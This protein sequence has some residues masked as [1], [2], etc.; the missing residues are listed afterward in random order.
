[1]GFDLYFCH[2]RDASINR[3]WLLSHL[4]ALEFATEELAEDQSVLQF[5]YEHPETGVYCLFDL[6]PE[7]AIA[8]DDLQL[9]DGYV[10]T[11]L[12]V[13]LNF[14]R[15]S[16]FALEVM[17]L[18]SRLS[19]EMSLWLYDPQ[20]DCLHHPGAPPEVLAEEWMAHNA[21]ATR[22][23]AL[24]AN[25]IRKPYLP[26]ASSIAWWRYAHAKKG[27]QEQL[28]DSVFV[29]AILLTQDSQLRVRQVVI[30]S[31]EVLGSLPFLKRVLPLPQV[32]PPCDYYM[33]SSGKPSAKKFST[34]FVSY[35]DVISGLGSLL[36]PLPGA[37]A[38]LRILRP[39][40]QQ[41]AAAVFATLPA[42]DPSPLERIPPEALSDVDLSPAEPHR[43]RSHRT[44]TSANPSPFDA[45]F[46]PAS[47]KNNGFGPCSISIS[48]IF[49][50][51]RTP[52]PAA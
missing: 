21:R 7:A 35:S 51:P 11:G 14:L 23:L 47:P 8:T 44:F 46:R 37:L 36:G 31:A 42:L 29:P 41:A 39:A 12:S 27:L 32:F 30:W 3:S 50:S 20:Q 26:A 13:S 2:H 6:L 15:P 38:G 19:A 40:R 49:F 34:R 52:R 18:V 9:P 24:D 33:L 5:I 10:S 4:R 17:P 48:S 16:F 22:G 25:P 28:G 45:S 43:T 1:M